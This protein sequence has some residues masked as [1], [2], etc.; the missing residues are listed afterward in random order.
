MD[1]APPVPFQPLCTAPR[2]EAE[3]EELEGTGGC[4]TG[5]LLCTASKPAFTFSPASSMTLGPSRQR[6]LWR[7]EGWDPGWDW[8]P[9]H[10]G[11]PNAALAQAQAWGRVCGQF[12][13]VLPVAATGPGGGRGME[14]VG[15]TADRQSPRFWVA[16]GLVGSSTMCPPCQGPFPG[17]GVLCCGLLREPC[18]GACAGLDKSGPV[19]PREIKHRLPDT[20]RVV[21]FRP[22]QGI[23]NLWPPKMCPPRLSC[24]SVFPACCCA[25]REEGDKVGWPRRPSRCPGSCRILV[26]G[27]PGCLDCNEMEAPGSRGGSESFLVLLRLTRCCCVPRGSPCPTWSHRP[28]ALE[29]EQAQHSRWVSH[30][31]SERGPPCSSFLRRWVFFFLR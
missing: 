15:W 27:A 26:S 5:L 1:A 4:G 20:Q 13:G 2:L 16:P 22:C 6:G 28:V 31:V 11:H 14:R 24:L 18:R 3:W 29:E 17:C 30:V 21:R 9:R 19:Q 12:G 25:P 8:L 23:T 7:C 10:S